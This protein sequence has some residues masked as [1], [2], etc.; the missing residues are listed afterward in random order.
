MMVVTSVDCEFASSE[1]RRNRENRNSP[2][3]VFARQYLSDLLYSLLPTGWFVACR[4]PITIPDSEPKPDVAIIL[5]ERRRFLVL[6]RHPGP[7][8]VEFL[9]ELAGPSLALD[10]AIKV[11]FYA[12]V[13]VSR[14]WLVDVMNRRVLVYSQPS[15]SMYRQRQVFVA[16]DR[17]PVMLDG[18][19]VGRIGVRELFL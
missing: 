10:E 17:V 3:R 15:A 1:G 4:S 9:I 8:E 7:T 12:A 19:E 16:G 13:G 18:R 5:G 2:A 6:N 11:R 14:C